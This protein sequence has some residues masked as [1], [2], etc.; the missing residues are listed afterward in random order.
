MTL[1]LLREHNQSAQQQARMGQ[2]ERRVIP[3]FLPT[4]RLW[5]NHTAQAGGGRIRVCFDS[6]PLEP[7]T[8]QVSRT[9]TRPLTKRIHIV[10]TSSAHVCTTS[11]LLL[12]F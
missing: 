6:E 1:P 4:A 2:L 7:L 3:G 10:H 12:F 5:L 9:C 8:Q 11:L